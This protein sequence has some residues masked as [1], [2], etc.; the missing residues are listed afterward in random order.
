MNLYLNKNIF[1]YDDKYKRI[2]L[3]AAY[4]YKYYLAVFEVIKYHPFNHL[5]RLAI[6]MIDAQVFV[7]VNFP[8]NS[9]LS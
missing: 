7:Y 5:V 2:V 3:V 9:R 4:R 6:K 1:Y 8:K